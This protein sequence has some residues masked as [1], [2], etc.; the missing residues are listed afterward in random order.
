[1]TFW[2][3]VESAL[4]DNNI[5]EAEL[6]KQ[7]GL[8]QASITGWKTRGSIPRADIAYKTAEI[9]NTTVEYLVSGKSKKIISTT[10][11]NSFVIPVLNQELSAGKGIALSEED[12]IKGF[13]QIPHFLREYGGNL[14]GLFVH[15]DSMEPTLKNGD[16][17]ICTS[18]GWDNEEGL[19]AIKLNGNGYVKRI[20][21]KAGFIII[22][23]DNPKYPPIEEPLGSDA[24]EIIGRVVLRIQKE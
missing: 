3:R 21:V 8:S 15:G 19:Y 13:I 16:L 18:L 14:A 23:S 12:V 17:V 5:S 6:S 24:F 2:E 20:Q 11:G 10:K 22:R 4:N 7:I 1:M 9:L